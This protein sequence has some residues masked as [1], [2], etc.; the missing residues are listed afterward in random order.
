MWI[1]H[2]GSAAGLLA[3]IGVVV[4]L[5]RGIGKKSADS[6]AR[7]RVPPDILPPAKSN[8]VDWA[9]Q[10]RIVRMQCLIAALELVRSEEQRAAEQRGEK[11]KLNLFSESNADG[12]KRYVATLGYEGEAPVAYNNL[13]YVGIPVIGLSMDLEGPDEAVYITLGYAG[14][15]EPW[16][17]ATHFDIKPL[18]NHLIDKARVI[19][20]SYEPVPA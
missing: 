13:V 18:A 20:Q 4:W 19:Y 6:A 3:F 2:F 8:N 1:E 9:R 17:L 12:G 16:P 7:M 11:G 15:A 10:L 14:V 5:T